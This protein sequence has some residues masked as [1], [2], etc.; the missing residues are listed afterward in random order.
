MLFDKLKE[1]SKIPFHM[2]GHKR[3]TKL[4][5][6]EF[7]YNI[8]I[9]EIDGFDNLHNPVD[10][11]KVIEDKAKKIYCSD[12]SFILVNGSTVGILAGINCIV[13]ENDTVLL[14]RN[15]HKSVYNAIELSKGKTEYLELP[16]DEYGIYGKIEISLFKEKICKLKPKLIVITSPTYEGVI[17][18]IDVICEIAHSYKIPVLLDAAH[19]AHIFDLPYKSKADIVIMSLHKTLPALTQCAVAHVNGDLVNSELFRIK[20]SVFETSSPSYVLMA[21]IDNCFDFI[22]GEYQNRFIEYKESR[23]KLINECENLNNLKLV[24]YDDITKLNIFTGYCNISGIELA[25]ILRNEFNIEVEMACENYVVLITT[26]CDDFNNYKKLSNAFFKIDKRIKKSF[27]NKID[28]INMP[29]KHCEIWEVGK[30]DY[31]DLDNSIGLTCAEYIWVYPP[32]SPIIVPGE[33]INE[34]IIA[35]IKNGFNKNLCI[36]S[37]RK[38]IKEKIYCEIV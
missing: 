8:D 36:Q 13:K 17:Y 19:G 28:T 2:P 34:E 29:K 12:N 11:I 20:L 23:D 35:F 14:T 15:C 27:F 22:N 38:K 26:V 10:M 37:S 6:N 1:N 24:V 16:V 7:P 31:F 25:D 5:G 21:S 30:C 33:V 9:T 4:L 3:N 18:D 32:G